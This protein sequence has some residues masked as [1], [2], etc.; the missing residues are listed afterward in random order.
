MVERPLGYEHMKRSA[1]VSGFTLVETMMVVGI[2]GLLAAVAIPNFVHARERALTMGCVNNMRRIED[3]A[4]HWALENR[5]S[6]DQQ[7]TFEEIE[8]YL[9]GDEVP[10][11]PI[12]G[13]SYTLGTLDGTIVS[14][15]VPEH[16]QALNGSSE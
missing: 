7:V 14:C 1:K 12:K 8:P 11:C 4:H 15:S 5:V 3:A 2:I 6:S 9:S 13:E 10:S 16:N